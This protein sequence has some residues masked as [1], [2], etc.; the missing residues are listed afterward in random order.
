MTS[1]NKNNPDNLVA[2]ECYTEEIKPGG[3]KIYQCKQCTRTFKKE[4]SAKQ[5]IGSAH[6]K[7]GKKRTLTKKDAEIGRT[8]KKANLMEDFE[9]D[10]PTEHSTKV[11]FDPEDLDS[12][13]DLDRFCAANLTNNRRGESEVVFKLHDSVERIIAGDDDT[14]QESMPLDQDHN[15]LEEEDDIEDDVNFLKAKLK[16]MEVELSNKELQFADKENEILSMQLEHSKLEN[17]VE[18]L[19]NEARVKDEANDL[20]TAK[21]N[22]LDETKAMYEGK[23][24]TYG[25]M[26]KK[27]RN[28]VKEL[29]KSD[30]EN[31]DDE[32]T[33]LKAVIKQK[34]KR[35]AENQKDLKTFVD[36][37]A[38]LENEVKGKNSNT[39]YNIAN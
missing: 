34:D 20:L 26:I 29:K 24:K 9:L 25:D 11:E 32:V 2:D 10:E 37:L 36:K 38:V 6:K 33:K 35:I 27:L 21:V 39:K 31:P 23:L 17:D 8:K 4:V 19:H 18:K 28:E 13:N 3:S 1:Q 16:S 7:Q 5:H 15:Y 30:S 22:A 14:L 12:T